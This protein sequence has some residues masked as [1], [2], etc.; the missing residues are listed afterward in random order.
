MSS[1]LKILL[2]GILIKHTFRGL[3]DVIACFKVYQ[4]EFQSKYHKNK[5]KEVKRNILKKFQERSSRL[6]WIPKLPLKMFKLDSMPKRDIKIIAFNVCFKEFISFLINLNL[7]FSSLYNGFP[8]GL[9]WS[10][11]WSGPWSFHSL[12]LGLFDYLIQ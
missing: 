8:I 6:P 2:K 11:L 3:V 10:T 5:C 12:H 1:L 4:T 7:R 9:V